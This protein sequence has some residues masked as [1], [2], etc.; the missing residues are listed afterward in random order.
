MN[1][2]PDLLAILCCP[3]TKQKVTVAEEA[4]IVTLNTLLTRGGLKNK[5]NR[6]VTEPFEGGLIREDGTLLYP[7]RDNIPVML[8]E[9][10]IPLAQAQ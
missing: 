7:I 1:I 2:N 9:E 5:G 8:I 10:G 4:V 6:P 3:E